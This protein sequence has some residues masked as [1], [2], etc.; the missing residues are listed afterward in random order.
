MLRLRRLRF[1]IKAIIVITLSVTIATDS[2]K[3][4]ASQ[5][6]HSGKGNIWRGLFDFRLENNARL[7]VERNKLCLSGFCTSCISRN[8]MNRNT[9]LVVCR[10]ILT[11]RWA[12]EFKV[13]FSLAKQDSHFATLSLLNH[14]HLQCFDT[15][16]PLSL[17]L[18]GLSP[19][20]STASAFAVVQRDFFKTSLLIQKNTKIQNGR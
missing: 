2:V 15:L 10:W 1:F 9:K 4:A 3:P 19:L 11:N 12:A 18:T 7:S 8:T 5:A 16:F 13:S 6:M 14:P 17:Y 20:C